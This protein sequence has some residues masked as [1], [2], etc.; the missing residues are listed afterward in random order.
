MVRSRHRRG[1]LARS[2]ALSLL[3]L[4]GGCAAK[5]EHIDQNN[6]DALVD[7]F[8]DGKAQL[9]C[10]LPCAGRFGFLR[11][12]MLNMYQAGNWSDLAKTVISTGYNEDLSWFYLARSAEG[13]GLGDTAIDYYIKALDTPFH[14]NDNT[15]DGFI[16]PDDIY[17]QASGL[18]V[19]L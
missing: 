11:S 18:G 13:L 14:C 4:C 9:D 3:L 8:V 17:T 12:A 15:C 7:Q 19:D 5:I 16:F 10:D 2:L 1:R 6:V